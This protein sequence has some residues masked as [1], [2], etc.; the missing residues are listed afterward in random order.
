MES[1]NWVWPMLAL[2][3]LIIAVA[4]MLWMFWPEKD[5][6][7]LKNQIVI[8]SVITALVAISCLAFYRIHSATEKS[9]CM[10]QAIKTGTSQ[11]VCQ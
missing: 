8:Y 3:V 11:T 10:D 4:A 5:E 7:N 9:D 1:V 6:R 2:S